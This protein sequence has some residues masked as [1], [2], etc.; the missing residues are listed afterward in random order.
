MNLESLAR[1]IEIR[2]I[3]T[4]EEAA[5]EA[6]A[7]ENLEAIRA[8][9]SRNLQRMVDRVADRYLNFWDQ[10]LDKGTLP[11]RLNQ[12]AWLEETQSEG[13]V[14][15][16][17]TA[18]DLNKHGSVGDRTSFESRALFLPHNADREAEGE[19]VVLDTESFW[20]VIDLNGRFPGPQPATDRLPGELRHY[21]GTQLPRAQ[22]TLRNLIDAASDPILNPELAES[23]AA[24]EAE[25]LNHAA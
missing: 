19:P 5:V 20:R 21:F 13:E 16:F 15:C 23:F 9:N 6:A 11:V 25:H 14:V 3:K 22:E 24:Y 12:S 8:F 10:V 17:L 4:A 18:Y 1:S 2:N 7:R